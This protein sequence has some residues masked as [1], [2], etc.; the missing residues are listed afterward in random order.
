MQ[1]SALLGAALWL[2][3]PQPALGGRASQLQLE[4]GYAMSQA[5]GALHHGGALGVRGYVGLSDFVMLGGAARFD[6]TTVNGTLAR[7]FVGASA[8]FRLDVLKWVPF[9]TVDVGAALTGWPG[10][11]PPF[12]ADLEVAVG[13]GVDYL[14]RRGLA[15]GAA[16]RYHVHATDPDRY[17]AML[18]VVGHV[19]WRFE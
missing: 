8:L 4:G 11:G 13:L 9:A 10:A 18:T 3:L 1:I 2:A 15:V 7:G 5:L 16:L 12:G 17:P 14:L 19:A 6:A